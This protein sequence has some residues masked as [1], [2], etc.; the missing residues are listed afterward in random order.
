MD[1]Q[2]I[3]TEQWILGRLAEEFSHWVLLLPVA[4]AFV[5]VFLVIFFRQQESL[6]GLLK[7][8]FIPPVA[9][10]VLSLAW[11]V[12]LLIYAVASI[13]L[14]MTV[15][16]GTPLAGFK[17]SFIVWGLLPLVAYPVLLGVLATVVICIKHPLAV[18]PLVI[19]A[20]VS[21]FYLIFAWIFKQQQQIAWFLV[22][23]PVLLVA[24]VYVALMYR[25]DSQSVNPAWAGFLG[26]LRCSV[27]AILAFIFLMPGCQSYDTKVTESKVLVLFD[28]TKSMHRV[29][30]LP[31]VG[32]DEKTMKK[33]LDQVIDAVLDSDLLTRIQD[34]SPVS[35]YRFGARLDDFDVRHYRGGKERSKEEWKDELRNFL[36]PNLTKVQDYYVNHY[37]ERVLAKAGIEPPRLDAH[38]SSDLPASVKAKLPKEAW[39]ILKLSPPDEDEIMPAPDWEKQSAKLMNL[40]DGLTG[41]TNVSGSALQALLQESSSNVQAI[42][43]VSDGQSNLSSSDAMQE[44]LT[45]ATNEKKSINIITVCV[46]KYIEPK[47]IRVEDIQAPE[48]ARPGPDKFTVQVPVYGDGLVGKDFQVMLEAEQ[49]IKVGDKWEP[50][51]G[52][53]KTTLPVKKGSFKREGKHA[54]DKVKFE[55]QPRQFAGVK[56]TDE[57]RD[58]AI[59][60]F[61]QFT[62]RVP[63]DSDENFNKGEHVSR[64][65]Y[66]LIQKKKMRVLLFSGGPSREY[67]FLRTLLFR[68][69]KENRLEMSIYLQSGKEDDIDQDVSVERLLTKFPTSLAKKGLAEKV[70][71]YDLSN[72]DVIV[73]LDPDW[74]EMTN[75]QLEN[76]NEWVT[77]TWSGGFVFSAGPINTFQLARKEK[78]VGKNLDPIK[79]LLPVALNDSRLVGIELD[80]TRPYMINVLPVAEKFD[81]MRP[82][83]NGKTPQDSWNDFFWEDEKPNSEKKPINGFFSYYPVES[84]RPGGQVLA[85]FDR[86]AV[87]LLPGELKDQPF[88]AE[89]TAGKGKV[90]YL[91]A[92]EF[93]RL[94]QVDE[95]FHKTF[96]M[97][98]INYAGIGSQN[99]INEHGMILA[100]HKYA[101]GMIPLEAQ[102]MEASKKPLPQDFVPK[103]H[104]TPLDGP[105]KDKKDVIKPLDMKPRAEG[106]WTGYFQAELQIDKPGQYRLYI[107]IPG[108]DKEVDRII[109]VYRPD[110]ETDNPRPNPD[111]LYELATTATPVLDRLDIGGRQNLTAALAKNKSVSDEKKEYLRTEGTGDYRL[112]FDLDQTNMIADCL[113]KIPPSEE[114]LKGS[115]SYLMDRGYKSGIVLRADQMIMAV[116]AA[117]G[118]IILLILLATQRWLFAAIVAGLTAV[119]V[120]G[121]LLSNIASPSW[122]MYP[123][124]FSFVLGAIAG[125]L[126]LEWLTRKLLRLA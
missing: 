80:P 86:P 23:G 57:S 113:F 123:I 65:S 67:Q 112:C 13:W 96:W 35:M 50:K 122:E 22:L 25:Q 91:G 108:T 2:I 118:A 59:E 29:D 47:E 69:Y 14:G 103:L 92:L 62:A 21:T 31:K 93:W 37:A 68:E 12:W 58:K 26:L 78:S 125:L 101:V 102:L 75:D 100:T 76:I 71:Y 61:W 36:Y 105:D 48:F 32:E 84:I 94:R 33:R 120:L 110:P 124:D 104:V 116:V 99:Q 109:T 43:I 64:P 66:T 70:K 97:Q 79:N 54:F 45:R 77:K 18:V 73:A 119:I 7:S 46:G 30:D 42:I 27:Y 41:A 1:S 10:T 82:S 8:L 3:R 72:Y 117:V 88:I 111:H 52:G 20:G 98:L 55:I 34:V 6:T 56:A 5:V 40:Y 53:I 19:V 60:G 51:P 85:N 107:P 39:E 9:I 114:G 17:E 106:V 83:E 74:T 81:F 89:R 4:F 87:K 11:A 16:A 38:E 115:I 49:V 15:A 44:L 90:I 28:I 95:E 121:V 63:R 24:L 126:C